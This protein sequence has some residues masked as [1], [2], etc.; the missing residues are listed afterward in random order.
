MTATG[1]E[2]GVSFTIVSVYSVIL[3]IVRVF[4]SRSDI[5][6]PKIASLNSHQLEE[7]ISVQFVCSMLG[8]WV[9]HAQLW[10]IHKGFHISSQY[11]KHFI[12]PFTL[13]SGWNLSKNIQDW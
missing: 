7:S 11:K 8:P 4:F 3:N 6:S 12:E 1:V 2:G 9:I 10:N 5:S 13:H